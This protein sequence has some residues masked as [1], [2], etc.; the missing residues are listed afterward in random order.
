[1]EDTEEIL[2]ESTEEIGGTDEMPMPFVS[3]YE[4]V[5]LSCWSSPRGETVELILTEKNGNA[6][7]F[8]VPL[9]QLWKFYRGINP[10]CFDPIRR[11]K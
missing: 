9:E 6:H 2:A 8:T 5:E 4:A 11:E 7:C 3:S 10:G 1:M